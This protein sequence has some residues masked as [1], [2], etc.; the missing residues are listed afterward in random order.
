MWK[1]RLANLL[2]VKSIVTLTMTAIL[3]WMLL[4]RIEPSKELLSLYCTTYGAVM[5]YYFNR[6]EDDGEGK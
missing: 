6:K 4:A 5:T 2:S 1:K 3:A